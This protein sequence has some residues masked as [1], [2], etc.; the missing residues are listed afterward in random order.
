MQQLW[1]SFVAVDV[2]VALFLLLVFS[3]TARKGDKVWALGH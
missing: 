1:Q 2:F 3:P